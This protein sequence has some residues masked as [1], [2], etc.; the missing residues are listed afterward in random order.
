MLYADPAITHVLE[1]DWL[2]LV[3]AIAAG[4]EK[5]L[6][7]LF[8]KTYPL[9]FAYLMRLTG[10][11]G[12]TED[13]ILEIFEDIWCEAPVFD[14]SNGPVLGWIVRQARSRAF[15]HARSA[16]PLRRAPD[17][18]VSTLMNEGIPSDAVRHRR[19]E[20]RHC[21]RRLML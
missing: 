21:R 6:R 10:D 20:A 4:D 8:E 3:H 16:E 14:D 2:A 1:K 17:H 15:A 11:R 9:V 12:M 13:V 5:A 7:V 19:L 18:I